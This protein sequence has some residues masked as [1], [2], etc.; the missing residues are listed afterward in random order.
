MFIRSRS[1]LKRIDNKLSESI[2]IE[3]RIEPKTSFYVFPNSLL[4]QCNIER[5]TPRC[6]GEEGTVHIQRTRAIMPV[7]VG[8][9]GT[10][11]GSPGLCKFR[12]LSRY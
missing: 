7:L 1:Y 6:L 3:Y 8:G 2:H 12:G 4:L 9:T 10:R 11:S 5:Q